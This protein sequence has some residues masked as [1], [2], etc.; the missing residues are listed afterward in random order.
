MLPPLHNRSFLCAII[1]ICK[2]KQPYSSKHAQLIIEKEWEKTIH[3]AKNSH[4]IAA[5][6]L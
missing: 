5:G 4:F 3:F 1:V 6:I 2:A